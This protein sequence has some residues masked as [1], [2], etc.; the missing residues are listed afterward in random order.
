MVEFAGNGLRRALGLKRKD[1]KAEAL[2]RACSTHAEDETYVMLLIDPS[3]SNDSV[4][5]S[6]FLLTPEI[7]THTTIE[8]RA[9]ATRL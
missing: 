5:I 7:Y 3:L 9:Y 2:E 4:N 1:I 8:Q 6:S